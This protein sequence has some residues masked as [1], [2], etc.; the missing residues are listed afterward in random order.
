MTLELLMFASNVIKEVC[1]VLDVFF[2][3][4][5]NYMKKKIP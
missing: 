3:F 4:R 2:S 1:V 5:R